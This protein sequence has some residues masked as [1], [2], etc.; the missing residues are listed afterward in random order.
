MVA[1][2]RGKETASFID[3]NQGHRFQI[4]TTAAAYVSFFDP[5]GPALMRRN[6]TDLKNAKLLWVVGS[7]DK[8]AF[9]VVTGGTVV[10]VEGG[11]RG[12]GSVAA[13]EVVAWFMRLP[14][15]GPGN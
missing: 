12:A 8:A 5:A 14:V 6:A 1:E 11:H 13:R 10:K 4:K 7:S 2:G 9:E 3:V 15:E